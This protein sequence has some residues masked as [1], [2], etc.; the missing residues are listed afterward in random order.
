MKGL[1]DLNTAGKRVL[2]VATTGRVGLWL[3]LAASIVGL[4][5]VEQVANTKNDAF[6]RQVGALEDYN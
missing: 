1:G 2:I 6:V 4:G 5:I 3:V